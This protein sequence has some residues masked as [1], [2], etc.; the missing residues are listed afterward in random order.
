MQPVGDIT[1]AS[2]FNGPP[3]SGNGG[4]AAGILSRLFDAPHTVRISA[5]IPLDAPLT[6]S[7]DDGT[8]IAE[9][10]G[11]R[12]LT[13]R[14][15]DVTLAPPAPPSMDTALEAAANPTSF[16]MGGPSTCFVCGRNRKEGEGLHIHCGRVDPSHAASVW[17]P[18]PNFDN[19]H[20]FVRPEYVWAALDCPGGFSLPVID[21]TYLLGEMSA[22][23]HQPV[24]TGEPVIVH[25][26]HEWSDG[27]K[28]FA[29]TAL[30]GKDGT[31]LAQ[32]DT[33]WI[34]LTPEQ[35]GRIAS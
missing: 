9:H 17:T 12:I 23:I 7:A 26:W 32:A 1:I 22:K 31:L 15:G 21:T 18:H 16:G 2:A 30:H 25:A 19:G 24:P 27:R 28:H 8:L 34:E 10:D 29:G 20:G 6:V 35:T 13:A 5:P 14:P 11:T 4:Y 33:L 3:N